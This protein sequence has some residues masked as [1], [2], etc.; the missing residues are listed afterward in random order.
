MLIHLNSTDPETGLSVQNDPL[1]AEKV[2]HRSVLPSD[3]HSAFVF[4]R[5]FG[6]VH[7]T[8]CFAH[9][10]I[11][12]AVAV[13]HAAAAVDDSAEHRSETRRSEARFHSL[14]GALRIFVLFC[15]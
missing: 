8:A 13:Q 3:S 14:S 11:H 9:A 5:L 12:V 15:S 1:T 2:H 10:G 7:V 4:L 6:N